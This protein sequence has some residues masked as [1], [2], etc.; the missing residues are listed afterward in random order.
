MPNDIEWQSGF[1][2]LGNLEP[3]F[4]VSQCLW[5]ASASQV[6]PLNVP[7][8]CARAGVLCL[9]DPYQAQIISETASPFFCVY[10]YIMCIDILSQSLSDSLSLSI[11]LPLSHRK[12]LVNLSPTLCVSQHLSRS[13]SLNVSLSL[14]LYVSVSLCLCILSLHMC[15]SWLF[16][17]S[18]FHMP[19]C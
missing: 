16:L 3:M 7:S 17:L 10:I 12:Y 18:R 14:S 2:L 5:L 1:V 6:S 8:D 19:P 11:C 13:L 4:V 9:L 15:L